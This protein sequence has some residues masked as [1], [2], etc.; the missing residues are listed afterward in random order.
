M[1]EPFVRSNPF[2]AR[3]VRPGAIPFIF[4]DGESARTVVLRL[5]SQNWRGEIIG[6]H[7]TGKSTLVA[8]LHAELRAFGRTP[9]QQTFHDGVVRFAELTPPALPL[10][11]GIVLIID[12]YEQLSLW[13]K[14]R[15]RRACRRAG[16][17][18]V[19]TA[20]RPSG[21]PALYRTVVTPELAG[22]VFAVLTAEQT[23]HVTCSDLHES[24]AARKGNLRQ[25][26]FD[27]YDLHE[28]QVRNGERRAQGGA[29]ELRDWPM[30]RFHNDRLQE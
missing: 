8:A 19:I 28:R 6:P 5:Q 30:N 1:S 16:C 3:F 15:V 29:A 24:L 25:A 13:Q 7:G 21:L 20:H 11:P 22:D 23:A 9:R 14:F 4:R 27:M 12:G 17:G 10:D 2:S 26:L 18:L